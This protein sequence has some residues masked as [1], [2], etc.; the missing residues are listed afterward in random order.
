MKKIRLF[1]FIALCCGIL[2]ACGGGGGTTPTG[3]DTTTTPDSFTPE[4]KTQVVGSGGGSITHTLANS[5]SFQIDIPAGALTS[6]TTFIFTTQKPVS[7]QRFNYLLQP[8]GLV[9]ANGATA[10][11]T[12]T[13][14]PGQ[15]LPSA[16]ALVYNSA[17]IP[18]TTLP[19]GRL[20]VSLSAFAGTTVSGAP[21]K[22]GKASSDSL[23]DMISAIYSPKASMAASANSCGSVPYLETNE[24]LS[25]V[26]AVEIELYG[27][28]MVSAVQALAAN[29]QFA[30]AVH[31][32]QSVAAYLQRT[33]SG[34]ADQLISQASSL[35]CTAY[36]LALDR[37]RTTT[38]TGMGTLYNLVKPILFWE[39]IIQQLGASCTGIPADEYQTVINAKTGEAIAYYEQEKANITD[40]SSSNYAA[41]KTEAEDS[42][43]TKNEVLALNPPATVRSAVNSE[44]SQRAQPGLLDAMLQA[45]WERCRNTANYDELIYLMTTMDSPE[46]VK[47]AAQ[48]CGTVLIAQAKD[49]QGTVTAELAQPMG[50]VSAVVKMTSG[51]LS[52]NKTS[53]L[54]LNGPI[55]ALQCPSDSAGGTESLTIALDGTTITTYSSPPY[56]NNPLTIDLAVALEAAHPGKTA[57]L[58]SAVL[59]V[60]RTGVPCNGFWGDNPSPLLTLTL[61]MAQSKI[62]FVRS[63]TNSIDIYVMNS[64]GS[65]ITQ[66]TSGTKNDLQPAW[67][68]DRTRIAFSRR[69]T[70]GP[71]VYD[72]YIMNADGTG[73]VKVSNTTNTFGDSDPSWSPDG[74]RIVFTRNDSSH[75]DHIYVMNADGS[76]AIALTTTGE[77]NKEPAWSPDGTKI[78]F[79]YYDQNAGGSGIGYYDIYLMNTNGSGITKLTDSTASCHFPS[80]SPDGTK[81]AFAREGNIYV[82]N[83]DG[84]GQNQLTTGNYLQDSYSHWSPDGGKIVFSR[85]SEGNIYSMNPDGSAITLLTSGYDPAW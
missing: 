26:D 16:G 29:E 2:S 11:I 28:C 24:G 22:A 41:A 39:T 65:G 76:G 46:A 25:A 40:T 48:Y 71:S 5:A 52:V 49:S 14:P 53:I 43:K 68:P 18:F 83:A 32:A 13:L 51:T 23:Q 75:N 6:D 4:T 64:D 67:S 72:I 45:P 85:Y 70:T 77:D 54:V 82:I 21:K 34:N 17:L 78:A 84:S 44:V 35:A 36:G 55:Q 58:T 7:G 15:S 20:Q 1:I 38:V 8:A 63:G 61:S 74:T 59:T 12:I 30:E 9:L 37:A 31:T 66:L 50:G 80:W 47:T 57:Q 81:I 33:G 27:Q 56:L 42:A 73:I 10:T 69:V 19:D 3:G 79:S 60:E 62:A